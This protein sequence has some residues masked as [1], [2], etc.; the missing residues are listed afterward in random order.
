MT[1]DRMFIPA[2]ESTAIG[3]RDL[4]LSVNMWER[5]S[6]AAGTASRNV[7]FCVHQSAYRIVDQTPRSDC[8]REH[9]LRISTLPVES[10]PTK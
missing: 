6:T 5:A 9:F 7:G 2:E 3:E 4:N 8:V 1:L 10:S